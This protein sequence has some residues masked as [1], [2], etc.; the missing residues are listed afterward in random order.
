MSSEELKVIPSKEAI[1]WTVKETIGIGVVN[2]YPF[3][4]WWK[5]MFYR[6]SFKS[7]KQRRKF[8]KYVKTIRESEWRRSLNKQIG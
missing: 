1:G 5:K 7:I 4:P 8:K 6:L 3:W 2:T